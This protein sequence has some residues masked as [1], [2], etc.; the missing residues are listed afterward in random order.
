MNICHIHSKIYICLLFEMDVIMGILG[1]GAG[2]VGIAKEYE[3]CAQ[4]LSKSLFA[5]VLTRNPHPQLRRQPSSKEVP[6]ASAL[7][8]H[9]GPQQ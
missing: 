4:L 1:G 5:S 3:N 9:P 7:Q 8:S 6:G 2:G